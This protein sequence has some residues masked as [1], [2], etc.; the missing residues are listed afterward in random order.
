MRTKQILATAAVL[1]VLAAG[2]VI[3]TAFAQDPAEDTP[4]VQSST[5]R[6]DR[7]AAR[8]AEL[9][10]ALAQ[11]L[12]LDA[13]TVAA[14][15]EKVHAQLAE[16]RRAERR[17]RLEAC[18]DSAVEAEELTREQAEALLDAHDA[19]VLRGFGGRG[20]HGPGE[21]RGPG[22]FRRFGGPPAEASGN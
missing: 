4:T 1:T 3:P 7:R 6:E 12:G 18:L 9:A 10:T 20:G 8:Q 22:G 19:G 16:Q 15:L 11:E 5:A 13:D 17:T 14:A 21:H 2:A